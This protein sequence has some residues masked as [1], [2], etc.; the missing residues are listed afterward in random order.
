MRRSFWKQHQSQEQHFIRLGSRWVLDQSED[1]IALGGAR[2]PDQITAV[3]D[4]DGFHLD[5]ETLQDIDRILA[6]NITRQSS[7][8]FMAPPT[9]EQISK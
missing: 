7:M 3:K 4:I 8:E 5:S 9:R 1:G 6:H 2:R